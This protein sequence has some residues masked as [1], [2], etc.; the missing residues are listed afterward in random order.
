MSGTQSGGRQLLPGGQVQPMLV[1]VQGSPYKIE[2]KMTQQTVSELAAGNYKLYLF[3]AVASSVGGGKPTVWASTSG[4]STL[5]TVSWTESYFGYASTQ[6]ISSGV[7]FAGSDTKG[8]N[9]GQTLDV[10][11]NAVATL[12]PKR[13]TAGKISIE[14]MTTTKFTCGLAQPSPTGGNPAPICAFPLYGKGLDLITPIQKVALMFATEP[15]MTGTVI[16]Q[17]FGPA[18]LVNLTDSN[19]ASIGYGMNTG[20]AWTG[21]TASE[22]SRNGFVPALINNTASFSAAQTDPITSLSIWQPS[23]ARWW[24]PINMLASG[25]SGYEDANTLAARLQLDGT[26]VIRNGDVLLANY[27]DQADQTVSWQVRCSYVPMYPDNP[28]E[29]QKIQRADTLA[30]VGGAI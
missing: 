7:D 17:S 14:N 15:L 19:N 23:R 22:I 27:R 5:T 2:I 9:L 1:D 25:G 3:K 13:G 30:V 12:D 4:Y 8:V 16:E 26:S 29:F 20:W 10:G 24:V 28:Y 6:E 18:L 11:P 21:D